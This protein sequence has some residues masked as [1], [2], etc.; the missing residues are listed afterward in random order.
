[1]E[2]FVILTLATILHDEPNS[3]GG[4][5]VAVV[6]IPILTLSAAG[7]KSQRRRLRSGE[8]PYRGFD[9]KRQIL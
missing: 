3:T 5:P 4:A 8:K 1:M 9:G 2:C 7:L 6:P